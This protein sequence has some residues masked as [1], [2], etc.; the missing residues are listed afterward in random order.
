ML[1]GVR[2]PT[3]SPVT[4]P[5]AVLSESVH[6]TRRAPVV[7]AAP[8]RVGATAT[9]KSQTPTGPASVAVTDPLRSVDFVAMVAHRVEALAFR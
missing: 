4:G 5:G 6:V 8:V 3:V 1:D 7:A 2:V 9:R